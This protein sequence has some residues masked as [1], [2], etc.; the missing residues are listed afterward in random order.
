VAATARLYYDAVHGGTGDH[1]DAKQR[2][3]WAP[4]VPETDA[5]ADRLAAQTVFVAEQGD[6]LV[7]FMTLEAGGCIDLAF[8]APDCTGRGIAAALYDRI[9]AAA[10]DKGLTRLTA[11][12]S[13]LLRPFLERRGWVVVREQTVERDGV[14]LTNFAMEGALT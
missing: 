4:A 9:V 11:D 13:H 10:R 8:V 14:A 3:A 12:A 7:G 5:W 2:R 1:Y 6:R